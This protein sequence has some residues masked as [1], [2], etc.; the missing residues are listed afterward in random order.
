MGVYRLSFFV[1]FL[2]LKGG[3]G[4]PGQASVD[5][6]GTLDL[7]GIEKPTGM[8]MPFLNQSRDDRGRRFL[9]SLGAEKAAV[10]VDKEC[11][12]AHAL[13]LVHGMKTG[14]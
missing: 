14:K 5:W 11:G 12:P 1:L 2:L 10:D 7:K 8:A 13:T 3:A 9:A 4:G 6:V